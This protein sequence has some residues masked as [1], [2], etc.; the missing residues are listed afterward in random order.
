MGD[1]HKTNGKPARKL[2]VPV[3]CDW[4]EGHMKEITESVI[5]QVEAM[6]VEDGAVKGMN[7]KDRKGFEYEF[8]N[9]EEY[10]MMVEPDEPAPFSGHSHGSARNADRT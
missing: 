2:Q 1:L 7:F 4:E 8:D 10:E 9:D 3:T 5:K 6:A